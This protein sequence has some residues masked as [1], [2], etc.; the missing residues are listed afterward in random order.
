[1]SNELWFQDF[2]ME[3]NLDQCP[4]CGHIGEP[5]DFQVVTVDEPGWDKEKLCLSCIENYSQ[6]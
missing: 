6:P 1:M 2:L 5:E 3:A 4:W